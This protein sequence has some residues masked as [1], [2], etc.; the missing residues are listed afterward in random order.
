MTAAEWDACSDPERM[1]TAAGRKLSDRKLLLFGCGCARRAWDAL[2]ELVR[3]TVARIEQAADATDPD[4]RAAALQA[5]MTALI[6]EGT[7][8]G[9]ATVFPARY[10]TLYVVRTATQVLRTLEGHE[11]RLNPLAILAPWLTPNATNTSHG[12]AAVLRCVAGNPFRK[13][14]FVPAWRTSNVVALASGIDTDTAFDRLP[15]LSDALQDAGCTHDTILNHLRADTPH[16]RGCWVVD[17]VLGK[18]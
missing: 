11:V 8:L 3:E 5:A 4:E 16:T 18:S 6:G 1:L 14:R 10:T 15:I 2:P 9:M 13:V 12:Q 17:L 7:F